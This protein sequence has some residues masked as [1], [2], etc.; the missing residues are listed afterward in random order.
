MTKCRAKAERALA[1]DMETVS[2]ILCFFESLKF[3]LALFAYLF[4][5]EETEQ[6]A[7]TE[8]HSVYCHYKIVPL[9]QNRI[10]RK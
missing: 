7:P 1:V 3:N 6:F 9:Y 5:E 2:H 10:I 8:V 4:L